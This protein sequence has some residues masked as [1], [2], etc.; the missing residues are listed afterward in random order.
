MNVGSLFVSI[1][2]QQ[3]IILL[4]YRLDYLNKPLYL[5]NSIPKIIIAIKKGL[6]TM[7]KQKRWFS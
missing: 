4:Q 5:L 7:L 6:L 3:A 1:D 2:T